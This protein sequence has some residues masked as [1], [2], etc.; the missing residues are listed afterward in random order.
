MSVVLILFRVVVDDRGRIC[1][2]EVPRRALH[3]DV[4]IHTLH[5]PLPHPA[6]H[7]HTTRPLPLPAPRTHYGPLAHPTTTIHG[8]LPHRTLPAT[9][10][11]TTLPTFHSA[12]HSYTR[13]SRSSTTRGWPTAA[14]TPHLRTVVRSANA[15]TTSGVAQVGL[16]VV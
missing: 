11:H 2:W 12:P 10:V 15:P 16:R 3:T 13:P 5:G 6:T 9:H 4:T 14:A 7:V 8:P 1:Y